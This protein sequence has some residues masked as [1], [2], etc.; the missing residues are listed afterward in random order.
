PD[1]EGGAPVKTGPSIADFVAG[2]F[3]A[4][5]VIT[6]LY[7]R[8]ANREASGGRGQHIDVALFDSM[9]SSLSHYAAQYLATGEVP[10]RRGTQG[11]GGLPSQMFPCADGGVM[12][13]CG[14]DAQYRRFCIALERP[15]LAD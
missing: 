9:V 2:Q 12:V 8:D 10:V 4:I 13:V 5:G 7:D 3:A 6:A 14:N 15:E 1:E 11:N